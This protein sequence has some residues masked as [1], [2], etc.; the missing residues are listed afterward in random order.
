MTPVGA[1][2]LADALGRFLDSCQI[3]EVEDLSK[4]DEMVSGDLARHWQESARF[5]RL[6]TERWPA[7]LA[8]MGL[9]DPA[10][11]RS[12]LLRLLAER[13]TEAP[14]DRP[15]SKIA[16]ADG[17]IDRHSAAHVIVP[18]SRSCSFR[19]ARWALCLRT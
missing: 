2:G 13:W 10:R 4:L 18:P 8:E 16:E 11:R 6:A 9:M 15:R 19:S 5:L 14:P 7:R 3:E 12:N 1:L 17:S